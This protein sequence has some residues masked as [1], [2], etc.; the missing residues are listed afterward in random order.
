MQGEPFTFQRGTRPI[1]DAFD[2]PDGL[3]TTDTDGRVDVYEWAGAQTTL[4]STGPTSGNGAFDVTFKG[5]SVDG[6]RVFFAT[7]EPLVSTDTDTAIDI[8]VARLVAPVNTARPAISGTP[9]VG[10]RL[11]CSP[12]SWQHDRPASPTGGTAP[13][14]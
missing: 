14:R 12:G 7:A 9:L 1:Q 11:S 6:I 10:R 3:V 2:T 4:V 5:A 13:A 8:Y